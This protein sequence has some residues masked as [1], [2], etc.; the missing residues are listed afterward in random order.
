MEQKYGAGPNPKTYGVDNQI[1]ETVKQM[2]H[3]I[4]FSQ[5][6][7][8]LSLLELR[9]TAVQ[10]NPGIRFEPRPTN[11][12]PVGNL[13]RTMPDRS[14]ESDSNCAYARL[15]GNICRTTNRNACLS[16]RMGGA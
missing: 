4:G 11:V 6:Y 3:S 8:V 13:V 1:C 9:L 14:R 12:R 2:G 16:A 15:S 10:P 7:R 5:L